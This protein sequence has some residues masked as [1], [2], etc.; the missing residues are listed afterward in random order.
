MEEKATHNL[1]R[2]QKNYS[3]SFKLSEIERG[4]L[5]VTSRQKKIWNSRRTNSDS[6]SE[7]IWYL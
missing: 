3:M 1:K 6:L 4:D 7:K 2:S 5:P